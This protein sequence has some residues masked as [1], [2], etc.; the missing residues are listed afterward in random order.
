M[1]KLVKQRA[2]KESPARLHDADVNRSACLYLVVK[3]MVVENRLRFGL[4]ECHT[5][6]RYTWGYSLLLTMMNQKY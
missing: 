1:F 6:S 2:I 3:M 5:S 4:Q